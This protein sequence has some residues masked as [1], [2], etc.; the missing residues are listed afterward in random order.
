MRPLGQSLTAQSS[1]QSSARPKPP[2]TV[3]YQRP[4]TQLGLRLANRGWCAA[5]TR[6]GYMTSGPCPMARSCATWTRTNCSVA[7]RRSREFANQ[8]NRRR[9]LCVV[10][11]KNSDRVHSRHLSCRAEAETSLYFLPSSTVAKSFT[12]IDCPDISKRSPDYPRHVQGAVSSFVMS[13]DW[14]LAGKWTQ[15]R[16]NLSRWGLRGRLFQSGENAGG[17]D[18]THTILRSLDF[19]SSAERSIPRGKVAFCLT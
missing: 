1:A 7:H 4:A 3:R 2:I 16:E 8:Q 15:K 17:G 6:G 10:D 18:R 5:R 9:P 14:S 12:P 11:L 13:S 19:E